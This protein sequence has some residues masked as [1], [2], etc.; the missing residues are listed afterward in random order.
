[1]KKLK[2][3]GFGL[4]ELVLAIAGS[5]ALIVGGIMLFSQVNLSSA[6]QDTARLGTT[7]SSETRAMFRTKADF[8]TADIGAQLIDSGAVPSNAIGLDGTDKIISTA[9]NGEAVITGAGDTFTLAITFGDTSN[10]HSLCNRIKGSSSTDGTFASGPL[11]ADYH[12]AAASC[13]AGAAPVL[14]ATYAR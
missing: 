9:Y 3:K 14:T 5:M 10:A 6:V 11:G 4:I 13:A 2:Q 8:G 7:L 1:M 12:V